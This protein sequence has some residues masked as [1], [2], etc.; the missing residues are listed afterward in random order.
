MSGEER[1]APELA[2]VSETGEFAV[3][4]CRF[5]FGEV[6]ARRA[7]GPEWGDRGCAGR[8]SD[9]AGREDR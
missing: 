7:V 5:F 8:C 6:L 3:S 2:S 1:A 4:L 9:D